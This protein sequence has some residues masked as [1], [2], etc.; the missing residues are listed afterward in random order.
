M[1]VVELLLERGGLLDHQ[2]SQGYSPLHHAVLHC[3]VQVV[4]LL[5]DQGAGVDIKDNQ[6][7]PYFMLQGRNCALISTNNLNSCW[8]TI[9]NNKKD[10]ADFAVFV[11]RF[12]SFDQNKPSLGSCEFF[13]QIKIMLV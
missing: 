10:S 11:N 5:L 12:F 6:G 7:K 4:R 2:D 8:F 3:Q 1:G 13:Y 9:S